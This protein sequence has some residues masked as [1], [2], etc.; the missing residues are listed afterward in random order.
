MGRLS[1]IVAALLLATACPTLG[2][3][4][5]EE[6]D[7]LEYAR[8]IRGRETLPQDA[9]Q[10]PRVLI[11]GPSMREHIEAAW[12]K[13][14]ATRREHGGVYLR[15]GQHAAF[16]PEEGNHASIHLDDGWKSPDRPDR[17]LDE[18]LGNFHT[19]PARGK[20]SATN[21]LSDPDISHFSDSKSAFTLVRS[22]S[23]IRLAIKTQ[24]T[25]QYRYP[26]GAEKSRIAFVLNRMRMDDDLD[27]DESAAATLADHFHMVY[28]VEDTPGRLRRFMPQPPPKGFKFTIY[29][30]D[31]GRPD[32]EQLKWHERTAVQAVLWR[33]APAPRPD[34]TLDGRIGPDVRQALRELGGSERL[35]NERFLRLLAAAALVAGDRIWIVE[36]G[37]HAHGRG[38]R[39]TR[40]CALHGN[41]IEGELTGSVAMWCEAGDVYRGEFD[42]GPR[43]RGTY[44]GADGS[45]R[46]G[47]FQ[48]SFDRFSGTIFRKDGVVLE[49][50]FDVPALNGTMRYPSFTAKGKFQNVGSLSG[51]DLLVTLSDGTV[52]RGSFRGGVMHGQG[53][54]RRPDGTWDK[55]EYVDNKLNG[56]GRRYLQGYLLDG[57]FRDG[58]F[59]R[60]TAA[61][62][63]KAYEARF[64][65]GS[66]KLV[67]PLN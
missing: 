49:G 51:H 56:K 67:R 57:E 54:V 60:G 44:I 35:T 65:G 40:H 26:G 34:P 10:A 25:N 14:L 39:I 29:L 20:I 3:D 1:L 52:K 19:H 30:I 55:G 32:I 2:W 4:G 43:G 16:R 8:R 50:D 46:D 21:A 31:D 18:L 7:L 62:D 41:W 48:G 27:Y 64:E 24:K 6:I 13:T 15:D 17:P 47:I 37:D 12:R 42:D 23:G 63:G 33:L 66:I 61:K 22:E 45:R 36:S 11:I 9:S 5:T 58:E 59:V 28:Y 53:E 38:I